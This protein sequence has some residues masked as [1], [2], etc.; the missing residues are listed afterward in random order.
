MSYI[1]VD[2]EDEMQ[3]RLR[4]E[5]RE[6]MRIRHGSRNY[7]DGNRPH[8]SKTY[9]DGYRDGYRHAVE[10]LEQEDNYRRTRDSR[11]RYL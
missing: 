5:M 6:N 7:Y 8:E 1:I 9:E 3:E 10:D 11:G 2:N 4:S